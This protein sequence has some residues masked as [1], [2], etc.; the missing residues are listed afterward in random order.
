MLL[1]I[2]KTTFVA[3][4]ASTVVHADEDIYI[5]GALGNGWQDW[6]WNTVIDWAATDLFVGTSSIKATSDAWA[7][8]SLKDPA[9]FGSYAG[10][11][12]DIAADPNSLQIYLQGTSDDAQSPSIPLSAISTSISTTAFTTV[13]IDFN[14]LPPS[15]APLGTGAW[16][17]ISFQALANGATYHLD[18]VQLLTSIVINPEFLTAEPLANNI[19]AVTTQG[20]VDISD[21]SVTLNNA[22]IAIAS[23]TSYSPPDTPSRTIHYLTLSSKLAPGTLEIA[24]GTL[25]TSYTLPAVQHGTIIPSVKTPISPLIYGVNWPPSASYI[26]QLGVTVSRWGGNAVTAYNPFGDFTNA[27]SDWYFENRNADSADSW[28]GWIKAAGS[29]AMMTIPALDWVAKDNSS[30]SYPKTIY[31]DQKAFDP[32]KPDAGNGLYPNGS[33]IQPPP[34]PNRG[35]VEWNTTAAHTWLSGLVN[36]PEFIFVDNEIEIAHSTHQDIHPQPMSYDEELDRVVSFAKVAKEA[37]PNVKV[38]APST[39]SWWFYWTSAVGWSDTAAH[40]NIDFLP[41]FL[42]QMKVASTAAGK[43]L[44]DYLDIHYYYQP[45][46]SA[47][48][49]ATKALRLR[50]TRSLWDPQYIDESWVGQSPQNH[51]PNAAAIWLIP[52]MKKLIADNYPGTKLSISEW[53]ST[54]DGDITGG[55]VTADSLGIFGRYGVDVATYW[56]NPDAKGPV[57]LAY[58]LYRGSRTYFGSSG[59]Q[60]NLTASDAA[61]TYGVYAALEGRKVSIVIVNKDIKPLALDLS[62]VPHGAYFMRHFGGASGVAKWQAN[63]T[64][65]S[66]QYIVVPSYAAIFLKQA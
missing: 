38:A 6:G 64:I 27:A 52:R 43:R 31:P 22:T 11:K 26:Q 34:D 44:L 16:D 20:D 47:N 3:L 56:S 19:V 5:D 45:D 13:V 66:H 35:Y 30:Y 57:G 40:D 50:M 42:A 48:D 39:C 29:Q 7:A 17:R 4:L 9:T 46:L 60:V 12:F 24:A 61:N 59:I 8:V 51:Q 15:G 18:N 58:W 23:H 32:Y 14:A 28:I 37:L 1:V 2:L 33:Y 54:A 21:V 36:M 55:L 62:N 25:S 63:I 41:W 10:L 53:A 65:S 49:A